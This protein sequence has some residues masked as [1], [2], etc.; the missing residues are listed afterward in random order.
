MKKWIEYSTEN[1]EMW[2]LFVDNEYFEKEEDKLSKSGDF[3]IMRRQMEST[4]FIVT[5]IIPAAR[6]VDHVKKQIGRDKFYYLKLSL[7]N[8]DSWYCIS[9]KKYEKEDIKKLLDLFIG[10]TKQQAERIWKAKKLGDFC[11]NRLEN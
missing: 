2:E 8:D 11:T 6:I 9:S 7:L 4:D 10:T 3:A 5:T 1:G